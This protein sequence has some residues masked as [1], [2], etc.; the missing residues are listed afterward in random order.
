LRTAFAAWLRA[1]GKA[2]GLPGL[3]TGTLESRLSNLRRIRRDDELLLW[4]TPA[5]WAEGG[6]LTLRFPEL[7]IEVGCALSDGVLT[8][9]DLALA[10]PNAEDPRDK[11][12]AVG[13]AIRAGDLSFP[14]NP[15]PR[16]TALGEQLQKHFDER[17]HHRWGGLVNTLK[18]SV[19]AEAAGLQQRQDRLTLPFAVDAST[20]GT[21]RVAASEA[22]DWYQPGE[23]LE[24]VNG[25]GVVSTARLI[26]A[27]SR[28]GLLDIDPSGLNIPVQGLVRPRPRSRLNEQK[29]AIIRQFESPTGDLTHLVRLV[30]APE[31]AQAPDPVTRVNFINPSIASNPA[32]VLAVR[33]A[34]GLDNGQALSIIGPPGTGK[35][36][37]A[38]E[39]NVQLV[40]RDPTTRVLVCSHSNHGTDN[41]LLKVLPFVPDAGRHIARV[42]AF[43][44][45]APAARH[46]FTSSEEVLATRNLVFTTIDSLG[47]QDLAGARMYDY[48]VLDEANRAGVID[49]LLALARG[50]RMI[51]IGDPMQLQPIVSESVDALPNASETS[52]FV[53]LMERGFPASATVFLEEQNRMHPA[54]ASLISHA[55]YDGRVRSG[56]AAPDEPASTRIFRDAVTWVDTSSLEDNREERRGNSLVNVAEARLVIDI[57]C[58]LAAAAPATLTIGVIAAYAQQRDLLRQLLAEHMLRSEREVEVDTVDAF[59]GREK[60]IIVLSLVRANQQGSIGFLRAEQRLNVALSRARRSLV[61]VGDTTMLQGSYLDRLLET[62]R[63]CGRIRQASDISELLW[64]SRQ[65]ERSKNGR[66]NTDLSPNRAD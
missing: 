39:I 14:A 11:P 37:T 64:E 38:A 66:A 53:W 31:L 54:I 6:G 57:T 46:C 56:P 17:A 2:N 34:L 41:L 21:L 15:S 33:L 8:A 36:T 58:H 28:E 48:V 24:L 52:L 45:V 10:P 18:R 44:R 5:H 60:D 22:G 55:F 23:W 40:R 29:R 32:Q 30:A 13:A 7:G 19:E 43:D 47:L 42:G 49:S 50:R 65:A 26:G 9:M 20:P 27:Q 4:T 16:R 35:S 25:V 12:G 59:E 1:Y 61:A 63:T 3:G 51:L 62:V